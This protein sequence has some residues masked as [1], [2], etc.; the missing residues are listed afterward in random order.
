[1]AAHQAALA[2]ALRVVLPKQSVVVPVAVPA[3]VGWHSA[4]PPAA[5]PD[6]ESPESEGF[7]HAK[8][9]S[10]SRLTGVTEQEG[11]VPF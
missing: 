6:T 2:V 3:A 9:S 10:N 7:C 5:L 8:P 1:M 4:R 11:S